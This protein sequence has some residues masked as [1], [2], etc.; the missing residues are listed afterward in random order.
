MCFCVTVHGLHI[1]IDIFFHFMF[2][3]RWFVTIVSICFNHLMS[4]FDWLQDRLPLMRFVLRCGILLTIIMWYGNILLYC[5]VVE[6]VLIFLH[7]RVV[8]IGL[9]WVV[10]GVCVCVCVCVC[11]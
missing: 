4:R 9:G 7:M 8:F 10:F 3:G 2:N 1:V 11:V 5:F 6:H